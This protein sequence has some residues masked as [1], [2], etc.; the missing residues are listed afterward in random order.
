LEAGEIKVKRAGFPGLRRRSAVTVAAAATMV[1][2]ACGSTSTSGG[3][4]SGPVT[5]TV[6]VVDNPQLTDLQAMAK[7]VYEKA[8]TN[9]TVKFVTLTEDTLRQAVTQ[10]VASHAGKYDV[11][12]VGPY[13]VSSAYAPNGWLVDLQSFLNGDSSYNQSDLIAGIAGSLKYKGDLYALPMYGESSF[14]MYRKDMFQ[15]AGL[16]MPQNPTWDQIA[17]YAKALNKPSQGIA[18][19]C[20]RGVNG[21]GENLAALDTVINAFGGSWFDSK[22]NAQLTSA[23]DTKAV[24]FYVN[25]VRQYGESGAAND[26]FTECNNA[27]NQGKA[28][29]WYDATVGASNLTGTAAANS[30]YAYAPTEDQTLQHTGWLW[31][32]ALAV[33]SASKNSTAAEQFITWATSQQYITAIAQ[34]MGVS[35]IPPGTRTSTYSLSQYQ[36]TASAYAPLVLTSINNA[37]I[38]HCC[39]N[40]VPYSGIQYV[41][42]PQFEALGDQ[43]SQQIQ[44]AIAGTESVSQAL[45]ASQSLAQ[46]VGATFKG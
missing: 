17:S 36:Q 2:A 45:Q 34:D 20:L 29:M 6:A 22:W 1:V 41:G 21:W 10:D 28:A 14:V 39:V 30:G 40:P 32:W 25:L 24:N 15:A 26:G 13:D 5:L 44:S 3:T 11:V 9:V 38:A 37:D 35:H 23:A 43:V 42:I 46:A 7:N 16:T 27:Y 19:I 33:E 18:G 12:A 8:H 4:T 31:S